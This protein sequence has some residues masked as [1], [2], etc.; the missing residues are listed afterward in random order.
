MTARYLVC[1]VY[2][3]FA[4]GCESAP[5]FPTA[6][7]VDRCTEIV[8]LER[9]LFVP[10]KGPDGMDQYET[11]TYKP[12]PKE[13]GI[14]LG[15]RLMENDGNIYTLQHYFDARVNDDLKVLNFLKRPIKKK[16]SNG[17][18]P[19]TIPNDRLGSTVRCQNGMTF[20]N[21]TD[22]MKLFGKFDWKIVTTQGE[23]TIRR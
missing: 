2:L 15:E 10:G 3:V 11:Y 13:S 19:G 20:K 5:P 6:P 9:V 8:A 7:E 18:T 16:R 1:L 21:G 4:M 14:V 12:T 23:R 17:E 22:G